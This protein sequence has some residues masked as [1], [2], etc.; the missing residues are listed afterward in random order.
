MA[1]TESWLV[2]NAGQFERID[3]SV[4]NSLVQSQYAALEQQILLGEATQ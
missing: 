1:K 2:N 4:E 3:Q